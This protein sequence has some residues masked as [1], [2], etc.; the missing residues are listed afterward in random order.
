MGIY[1]VSS[2]FSEDQNHVFLSYQTLQ[3]KLTQMRVLKPMHILDTTICLIQAVTTEPIIILVFEIW[4]W[5][6]GILLS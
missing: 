1:S 2:N 6:S 5:N 4:N 3:Y